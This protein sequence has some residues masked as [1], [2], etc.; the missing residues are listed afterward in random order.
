MSIPAEPSLLATARWHPVLVYYAL[1]CGLSWII[2]AAILMH[3]AISFW[4]PLSF[5]LVGAALALVAK[6]RD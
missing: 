2:W 5:L 6:N 1:A 3:S 4:F